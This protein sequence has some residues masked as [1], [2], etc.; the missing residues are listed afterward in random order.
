MKTTVKIKQVFRNVKK[1]MFL[2]ENLFNDIEIENEKEY[3]AEFKEIKFKRTIRQNRLMWGLIKEIASHENMQQ[4]E[5]EIYISALEQANVKSTYLLAPEEAEDILRKNFRAVKVVRP[6][7][8]KGR[9]M[10][11]YKCFLGSSKLNTKEMT[12]LLDIIK[13]WAEELGIQTDEKYFTG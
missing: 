13:Y 8:F 7:E 5:M 10:Y 4:D 6:E 2:I 9:K 3:V 12:I 11:V 1:Q